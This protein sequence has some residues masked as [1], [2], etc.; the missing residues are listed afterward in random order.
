MALL[1]AAL[2][3]ATH[4]LPAPK[5]VALSPTAWIFSTIAHSEWCPAGN[6][7]LDLRT[8]E[9]MLTARAPRRICHDA[10]VE[11]P[12]NRGRLPQARLNALRAAYS[13]ALAQGLANRECAQ[14][15]QPTKFVISNGG[16]PVLVLTTG[17]RTLSAPGELSCWSDAADALHAALDHEFPSARRR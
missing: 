15:R 1:F 3:A 10:N 16:T 17:Q 2:M 12:V 14:G 9:Y 13:Q 11:R 4:S 6:V 8:G 7:R 5:Q